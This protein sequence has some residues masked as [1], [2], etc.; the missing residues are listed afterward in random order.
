M[1]NPVWYKELLLGAID[2]TRKITGTQDPLIPP[3]RKMY[4]GPRGVEI[5]KKNGA[6]FFRYFIELGGL[7]PDHAVM[8]V[9]S[10]MGRKTLPLTSYLSSKGRYEGLDIVRGGVEWC[11]S[12][13]TTRFP[14]FR[15]Q[16]IN[17]FNK[18]YNPSGKINA[19]EYRFPFES[20]TF[21]FV[22]LG[23]VF[24]HMLPPAVDHYLSEISRVL[25]PGGKSLITYFL[26]NSESENLIE[27]GKGVY[28]LPVKG[29]N[30]RAEKLE[31]PED[32]TALAETFVR[33]AYAKFHC[34][35]AD[36]IHYGSW[37]GRDKF[38]SFQDIVI[39]VKQ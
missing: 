30:Y 25:K 11:Q 14:N 8:D 3:L 39:A 26:L 35:I 17:V 23:S 6:E 1:S 15:F 32:I 33:Q 9:G 21:D 12:H 19:A 16:H 20:N 18:H 2:L 13:I 38:L 5:F 34:V 36:P 37:C 31:D 24:T 22:V 7:K 4:D 28:K 29:D 27:Q 10:G